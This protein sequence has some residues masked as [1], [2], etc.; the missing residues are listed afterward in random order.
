ML[1]PLAA[2][3]RRGVARASRGNRLPIRS[4]VRTGLGVRR[5]PH[6][7]FERGL[8]YEESYDERKGDFVALAAQRAERHPRPHSARRNKRRHGDQS[9]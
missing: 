2:T 7:R 6:R 8:N 5:V 1:R 4:A 3:R 9:L